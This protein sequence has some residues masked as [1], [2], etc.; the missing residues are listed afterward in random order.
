[1]VLWPTALLVGC[2]TADQLTAPRASDDQLTAARPPAAASAL[3]AGHEANLRALIAAARRSL[4]TRHRGAIITRGSASGKQETVSLADVLREHEE[5]LTAMLARQSSQRASGARFSTAPTGAGASLSVPAGAGGASTDEIPDE[6]PN[7]P[8]TITRFGSVVV[9][10]SSGSAA[11]S[12]AWSSFTVYQAKNAMSVASD[13]PT[14]NLVHD[15]S[16]YL[17]SGQGPDPRRP[18]EMFS[19]WEIQGFGDCEV[20]RSGTTHNI[21]SWWSGANEA[22]SVAT[23]DPQCQ[24]RVVSPDGGSVDLV[25]AI[26]I[27]ETQADTWHCWLNQVRWFE[28]GAWGP[29]ITTSMECGY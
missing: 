20:L 29:W 26:G 28:N 15:W 21:R 22:G 5:H 9:G 3:A 17:Q 13:H 27:P 25:E 7:V 24:T 10:G 4:A 1:M 23:W 19:E 2:A 6:N 11:A 12:V 16:S 14:L 8:P 18:F